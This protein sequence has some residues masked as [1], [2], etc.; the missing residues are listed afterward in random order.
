MKILVSNAGST[1]LKFK[2]FDM[3]GGRAL[4]EARVER[5]GSREG[6]MFQYKNLETGAH[7]ER[8]GLS[9]PAYTDGINLFLKAATGGDM[10]VV[11]DIAEVEAVGFKTVIAPG[12]YGVHELD[13]A[14]MDALEDGARIAPAHNL[15][16]I[17]AINV[18]RKLLPKAKMVGAFETEFHQTIPEE[19]RIYSLPYEW[20]ERYGIRRYGYHGA[21]HGYIAEKIA[22]LTDGAAKKVISCHL[23]GS[24]SICAI[25][26][27][28]SVDSTCGFSLQSGIPHASRATSTP[29]PS[30]TCFPRDS[31][32]RRSPPASQS[33][34]GC[35]AYPA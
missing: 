28:K 19:R 18:F 11:G 20:N 5:V 16:Y 4:C 29:I 35:W 23:G 27:G 15:P 7:V 17:E 14:V 32:R 6:A 1:S 31:R 3:E 25:D 12:F 22:E 8:E 21:S 13:G 9:V 34:A 10:G 2:L 24:G 30:P 26:G 33:A